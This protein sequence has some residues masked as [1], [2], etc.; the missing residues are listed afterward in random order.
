MARWWLRSAQ[1]SIAS[2]V[3]PYCSA[4]RSAPWPPFNS[5]GLTIS[6][7]FGFGFMAASMCPPCLM[8]SSMSMPSLMVGM[9]KWV[10]LSR[11]PA[12]NT[13]P[14]PHWF[15]IAAMWTA[16]MA[17]VQARSTLSPT[18]CSGKPARKGMAVPGGPAP[19]SSRRPR[20]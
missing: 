8:T 2:R 4:R 19:P 15:C 18:T 17:V 9:R 20:G 7:S 10:M 1:R 11:P 6:N 14:R 13:S 3:M 12:R 16:I 5:M